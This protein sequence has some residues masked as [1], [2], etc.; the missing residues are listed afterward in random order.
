MLE[1]FKQLTVSQFE[2]TLC[3]LNACIDRCPDPLWD[4]PVG[5]MDFCQVVFHTLFF[6]DLYLGRD[7]ESLK[8]QPFHLENAAFFAGYEEMEDRPPVRRYDKPSLRK[9]LDHCRRKAAE[10]LAAETT[11]TLQGPSGFD[12]RKCP[13]AEL[14]LYSI[15]HVQHHAAMLSLK[16][17]LEAGVEVPWVG[18]GWKQL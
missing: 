10:S 15:R 6:T 5:N 9:Y 14:H 2:A 4:R 11:Q 7:V 16:L 12:W 13:R 18:S 3:T 8:T 17:R 1:T